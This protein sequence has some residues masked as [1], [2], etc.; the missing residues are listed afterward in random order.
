MFAGGTAPPR[1][2]I[3]KFH[4]LLGVFLLHAWGMTETSPIVTTGVAA[5]QARRGRPR[6][7]LVDMQVKQGRQVYGVELRLRRSER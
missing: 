4:D 5:G 7:S 2:T 3:E 6:A 1:A